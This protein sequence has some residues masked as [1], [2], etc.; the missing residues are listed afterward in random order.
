[1]KKVL[2]VLLLVILLIGNLVFLTAC[3]EEKSSSSETKT[4]AS[5]SIKYDGVNV[6]P[7]IKFDESKISDDAEISE[8]PSCAFDGVDKVYTY[9]NVEITVAEINGTP[10]VYS[11]YF[12]DDTISTN[13]GVKISDSKDLMLEKYGEDYKNTL[14]NKY[15]YTKGNVELSFIVENDIVTGI[16]YTLITE[17]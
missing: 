11:V 9:S 2:K 5:F 12:K 4:K 1:M 3:G 13:E 17:N 14:S 15:D 8:I 7:G 16:E 10:T 6:V